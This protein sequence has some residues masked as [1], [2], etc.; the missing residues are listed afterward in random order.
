M[1]VKICG[2]TRIQDAEGAID[3]GAWA[4]G[5]IFYKKSPRYIPPARA[6][7]IVKKFSKHINFVGVFVNDSSSIVME[8]IRTTGINI[9]Q[10]H[11]DESPEFC[12]SIDARVIKAIRPKLESD[13]DDLKYFKS[14][15]S[16]LIDAATPGQFGGTG[17]VSNW[18]LARLARSQGQIFLSGGLHS[19]NIEQAIQVVQP[20]GVDISSGV[21]DA[22]GI[23]S[24]QKLKQLFGKIRG[25]Q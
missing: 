17:K 23:K 10:L 2:I 25:N 1:K 8:T 4:L 9:V 21:E 3:L 11:G 24:T 19:E 7:L 15:E 16:F 12:S 22:P 18:E 20:Y 5:F 6:A 14:A 13:I